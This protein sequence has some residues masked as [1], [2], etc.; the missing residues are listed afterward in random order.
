MN[1]STTNPLHKIYLREIEEALEE[2]ELL[3]KGSFHSVP[4]LTWW[5]LKNEK[6][7]EYSNANW[8]NGSCFGDL[9]SSFNLNGKLSRFNDI[10]SALEEIVN[11][12]KY[13]KYFEK[14][15]GVLQNVRDDHP[16]LMQWLKKNEKLGT[17]DFLI[18]WTEWLEEGHT[19]KPFILGWR[20]LELKFKA[21]EWKHT[22]KFLEK[23]NDLYW[24]SDVCKGMETKILF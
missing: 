20:E 2:L 19:V 14:E 23:F 22:I 21:E 5:I 18:F 7:N 10:Y 1:P 8:K 17:E 3:K 9:P 6:L 16:A 24:D 12:Y 15:I 4:K 11:L 13:E